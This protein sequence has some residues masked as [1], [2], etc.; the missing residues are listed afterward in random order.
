MESS[1][2]QQ[3]AAL[4]CSP[5]M[6]HLIIPLLELGKRLVVHQNFIGTILVVPSNTSKVERLETELLQA[7]AVLETIELP[8]PDISGVANPDADVVTRIAAMMREV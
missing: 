3:H 1:N 6:G 2:H 8:P 4:L 5:G 7:D